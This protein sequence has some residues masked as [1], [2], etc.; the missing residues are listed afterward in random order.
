MADAEYIIDISATMH[1]G[2]QTSAELDKLAGSLLGAGKDSTAFE[3]AIAQ[4]AKQL[5][6]AKIATAATSAELALASAEY[7]VLEKAALKASKAAERAFTRDGAVPDELQ[8][9]LDAAQG[10]VSAYAGKLK[11]LETAADNAANAEKRLASNMNNIRTMSGHVNKRLG[12]A[13]QKIGRLE[14]A[15]GQIGG[16]AGRLGQA[17]VTPIKAFTELS[18]TFGVARAG[19]IVLGVAL[20]SLVAIAGMVAIGIGLLTGAVALLGIKLADSKRSA[21]LA[22]EALEAMDPSLVALRDD[23]AALTASTGQSTD[24]LNGLKKKLDDAKVPADQMAKAL[25]AA[26]VAET[27][28]GKGGADKFI[29]Q[30]KEGKLSVDEF[31]STTQQKLGGIVAK[32]MR[33]LGAQTDTLSR[34]FSDLFGGLD[35]DSALDGFAKLVGLFDKNTAAGGA[36]KFLFESIFQ[37]LIDKVDATATVIEAFWLGFLIGAT[38]IYIALK[39]VIKAV[40]EFFGF[41]DVSLLDMLGSAETL[42][43]IVAYIFGG[44]AVILGGVA[45]A[46]GAVVKAGIWLYDQFTSIFEGPIWGEIGSWIVKGLADGILGGAGSVIS[47]MVNVA[48]SAIGAAKKALGI[49]SPSKVFAELGVFTG[50]GFTQGI[51]TEEKNAQGALSALVAPPPPPLMATSMPGPGGASGGAETSNGGGSASGG[52]SGPL[53]DLSGS[54]FIFNGVAGA[55]D[56]EARFGDL[57]T[58]MLEGDA[59]SL[60]ASKKAA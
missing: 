10:A 27:A 6:A 20:V 14:G 58:K 33:G 4:T 40:S 39:P 46:I 24:A 21:G 50:E 34:N 54:T 23:F 60:G 45:V 53:V 32:Q 36:M 30:I 59:A 3:R 22:Q 15:L 31:A 7:K 9:E 29:G 1:D 5:D 48:K 25:E 56:A 57:M 18:E 28:L 52:G 13:S 37:P 51:E 8:A 44:F 11:T 49:A 41:D 38:Q 19:A 35:I 47:A 2:P 16:P 42:G 55:E 17:M 43:T 26:A 12:E